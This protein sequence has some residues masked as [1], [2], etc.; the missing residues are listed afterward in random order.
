LER[1]EEKFSSELGRGNIIPGYKVLSVIGR[2]SMGVVYK[3]LQESMERLVALKVL[4][5]RFASDEEFAERFIQ[6]ARS[7]ARLRHENIVSALDAGEYEGTYYF[8]MEFV[9]G[10][11]LADILGEKGSL[12]AQEAA[13]I[14]AQIGE[15]LQHAHLAGLVH[16]DVKPGNILL[17]ESGMAK[18]CDLGLTRP[19]GDFCEG[20]AEGTPFYISP[21]QAKGGQEVDRRA[22]IY[23]LGATFYHLLTGKPPFTGANAKE[24]IRKHI[25]QNVT[26]LQETCPGVPRE[27]ALIV[28]KMLQKDAGSRYDNAAQVVEDIERV[29]EGKEPLL[30]AL[31]PEERFPQRVFFFVSRH[32]AVFTVMGGVAAASTVLLILYLSGLISI[33]GV[34]DKKPQRG[35]KRE[36]QEARLQRGIGAQ[37]SPKPQLEV[38]R[39]AQTPVQALPPVADLEKE[40]R[41]RLSEEVKFAKENPDKLDEAIA[42]FETIPEQYSGTEAAREARANLT[43]LLEEKSRR[44]T[45]RFEQTCFLATGL[46]EAGRYAA[47]DRLWADFVENQPNPALK[48]KAQEQ[49]VAL[50]RSNAEALEHLKE[51]VN[52]LLSAGE[53]EKA[54]EAVEKFRKESLDSLRGEVDQI[55]KTVEARQKDKVETER[56]KQTLAQFEALMSEEKYSEAALLCDT[57]VKS[58]FS[59]NIADEMR[60]RKG[61]AGC[62]AEALR[63]ILSGLMKMVD[64]KV[65]LRLT[66]ETEVSGKLIS[67]GEEGV[68]VKVPR[69]VD[70]LSLKLTELDPAGL[71]RFGSVE[72]EKPALRMENGCFLLARGCASAAEKEFGEA[73]KGGISV[74]KKLLDYLAGAK[75]SEREMIARGA[76]ERAHSLCNAKKWKEAT[77]KFTSI[78][79]DDVIRQTA[80]FKQNE[81]SLRKSY[82]TSLIELEVSKGASSVLK[83]KVKERGDYLTIIYDFSKEEQGQD[84]EKDGKFTDSAFSVKSGKMETKGKINLKAQFAGDVSVEA[85]CASSQDRPVNIGVLINDTGD[86]FYLMGLGFQVGTNR[87]IGVDAA[88]GRAQQQIALPANLIL[89]YGNDL[90]NAFALFGGYLPRVSG[91]AVYKVRALHKGGVLEFSADGESVGSVNENNQDDEKGRIGFFSYNVTLWITGVA[92]TGKVEEKWLREEIEK[93]IDKQYSF[94]EEDKQT[95]KKQKEE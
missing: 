50:E 77:E 85:V 37:E 24:I 14:V 46:L 66:D 16:R 57:F 64:K 89:R 84:W 63:R 38:T 5:E 68:S 21:E 95:Q 58:G 10:R 44:E 61:F 7:V 93:K 81:K 27:Y 17:S 51:V 80:Y 52:N 36:V 62:A 59:A 43:A 83:G 32:R 90:N 70:P 29:L 30:G 92:I 23:S 78:F 41:G 74:E 71:L 26:P 28:E 42:R 22:D 6:E 67:A 40:A 65:T 35:E 2:G 91:N 31:R 55:R 75:V 12:P 79:S 53:F 72:P 8:V 39:T 4:P 19:A 15:A 56:F 18:L 33:T 73:Q 87:H 86:H 94:T 25:T 69:I 1:D 60:W 82:R 20:R 11:N 76:S 9:E 48:K 3:A 45:Q 47:A 49:L 54:L 34:E 88:R 13:R